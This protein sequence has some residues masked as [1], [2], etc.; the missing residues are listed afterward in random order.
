MSKNQPNQFPTITK[1]LGKYAGEWVG[2]AGK[3]FVAHD[4]DAR[5]VYKKIRALFPDAEPCSWN[6]L[7]W[8][9]KRFIHFMDASQ[10]LQQPFALNA[11]LVR[12]TAAPAAITRTRVYKATD[13][14]I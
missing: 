1:K 11:Q 7:D 2:F 8:Q 13:Q 12:T 9:L 10:T 4:K 3:R 5:V 14:S 6:I